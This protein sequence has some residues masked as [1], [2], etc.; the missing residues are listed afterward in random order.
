MPTSALLVLVPEAEPYVYD[1]RRRYD[2][3][4]SLG[5]PA[6]ITLTVP[7][8]P[9]ERIG[10]SDLKSLAEYFHKSVSF[11]FVLRE[12]RRF[13]QTAYLF[14]SPS[15][16][17]IGLIEGVTARFPEYPPYGGAFSEVIPHLTIVD[18]SAVH[19]ATVERELAESLASRGPIRA[20]CERV[21][22]YEDSTG[23]WAPSRSF[24]VGG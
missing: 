19:A 17:F 24:K 13:P 11:D 10:E 1:L 22:L 5:M 7:F 8:I 9:P 15:E 4:A 18:K 20:S 12:V 6:H 3:S 21:D 23:T 14:P 2:P 16:P